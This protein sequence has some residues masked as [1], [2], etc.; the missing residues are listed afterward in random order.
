MWYD[1]KEGIENSIKTFDGFMELKRARHEAGY[2]RRERMSEWLVLGRYQFDTCGNC[3]WA[4]ENPPKD[5]MP[6][7]PD[8]MTT[9]EAWDYIKRFGKS[10][11]SVSFSLSSLP[12]PHILCPFCGHGW[13]INNC[14]DSIG[15]EH[16]QDI[17]LDEYI[18]KTLAEV[19]E[20]FKKR[21][22]GIYWIHPEIAI[23][24]DRFIDLTPEYPDPKDEY[25][26]SVVKNKRGWVGSRQGIDGKYVIQPGDIAG[27]RINTFYHG[28]CNRNELM[29]K[30][31]QKFMDVFSK[32]GINVLNMLSIPN[33]Y[34]PCN[35]CPP[36]FEVTT[37]VGIITIGWR[38]RV[39]NIEWGNNNYLHL[40]KAEDVTKDEHGIHAWGYERAIEYLGRIVKFRKH[41]TEKATCN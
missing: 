19:E 21:T 22:D 23:R 7:I 2:Q 27:F 16:D 24:N 17:P 40:F 31:A 1:T 35:V 3:M 8:V 25:E 38:K 14:H 30:E 4:T 6:Y 5:E 29:A 39:I 33:G 26:K 20:V 11:R 32:A 36:W 34:C 10:K 13:T 15:R 37:D 12:K 18:G 9:Q 41:V 28:T